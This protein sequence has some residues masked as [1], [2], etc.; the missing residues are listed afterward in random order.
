MAKGFGKADAVVERQQV[1]AQ[2]RKAPPELRQWAEATVDTANLTKD[3]WAYLAKDAGVMCGVFVEHGAPAFKHQGGHYC[4]EDDGTVTGLTFLK[5]RA[6]DENVGLVLKQ[7]KPGTAEWHVEEVFTV[8]PDRTAILN[9][10]LDAASKVAE[11]TLNKQAL[12]FSVAF[13]GV[14]SGVL[15]GYAWTPGHAEEKAEM[16]VPDGSKRKGPVAVSEHP[17]TTKAIAFAYLLNKR[18]GVLFGGVPYDRL[19]ELLTMKEETST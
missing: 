16:L 1:L 4:H 2:I 3:D 6:T 15:A 5:H 10:D 17:S 12:A 7:T 14:E 18:T 13:D 9:F 11:E 19:R 8:V